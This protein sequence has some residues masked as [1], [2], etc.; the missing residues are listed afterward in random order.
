MYKISMSTMRSRYSKD[1]TIIPLTFHYHSTCD[2]TIVSGMIVEY[3]WNDSA[4][5]FHL[6]SFTEPSAAVKSNCLKPVYRGA[7]RTVICMPV[8]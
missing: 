7:P 8:P 1:S 3:L 5:F 6:Y 4:A 2:V